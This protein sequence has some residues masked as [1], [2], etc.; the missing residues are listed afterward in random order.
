MGFGEMNHV[1]ENYSQF[2]YAIGFFSEIILLI[3]V[4]CLLYS[5]P[6]FFVVY[7]I[8]SMVSILLNQVIKKWTKD[9]RP[10]NPHKFLASE[11]FLQ[12][13]MAYGMPSGH[14]QSTF[15]SLVL[16][17]LVVQPAWNSPWLL[18]GMGICLLC[19]I[20]RFVFRNHTAAQLVVGAFLGSAIAWIV[21]EAT[22]QFA[23]TSS[24]QSD[25]KTTAS[26]PSFV[27]FSPVRPS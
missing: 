20:E 22:L 4:A 23:S 13:K 17:Y 9:P 19:L 11:H 15:F 27:Q 26:P 14:A 2:L 16:Y 12:G 18:T 7:L 21:Y 3:M 1:I 6:P 25:F 5:H 24:P 8:A 10:K